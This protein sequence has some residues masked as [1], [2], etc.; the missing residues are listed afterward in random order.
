[1]KTRYTLQ[2]TLAAA[3]LAFAGC[4]SFIENKTPA[5]IEADASNIYTFHVKVDETQ[6]NVVKN[7]MRVDIV[8]NG[9]THSM[10]RDM[11]SGRDMWAYDY[12]VPDNVSDVPYYFVTHF[13]AKENSD[14]VQY[15]IYSSDHSEDHKVYKS[16]LANR[17][18]MRLSSSRTPTGAMI[19]VIGLGFTDADQIL[20]GASSAKTTLASHNQINF[21]VPS[22]LDAGHT[23]DVKLHTPEGDLQAGK[24][25][26]DYSTFGV[27]PNAIKI[28]SGD[29]APVTFFIDT[30]APVG[31]LTI[32]VATNVSASVVMPVVTIPEGQRSVSVTIQGAAAGD[33]VLELSAKNFETVRV[34]VS[35]TAQ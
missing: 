33:G 6:H 2:I 9:E 11:D 10:H 8:I 22:D 17:F 3:V 24:L 29:S 35:I 27:Q 34:P 5:K 18:V 23:Y 26:I 13:T 14:Y 25:Y 1:M 31:G 21:V 32:N 20:V 7:T 19:Q 4:R 30:P 28:K 15:T 16:I 12:P